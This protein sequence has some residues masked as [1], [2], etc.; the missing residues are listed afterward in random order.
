MYEF[1]DT[2]STDLDSSDD[3]TV[4]FTS[5][6]ITSWQD[7]STPNQRKH[8]NEIEVM[9]SVSNVLVS[10]HKA[11]TS[12]NFESPTAVISDSS[13]VAAPHGESTISLA[14]L[15]TNDRYYRFGFK[16]TGNLAT[17]TVALRAYDVE[18]V[19]MGS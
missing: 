14:G 7:F 9:G 16:I 19:L 18:A 11:T 4:S 15:D 13:L 17:T 3:S 8:L 5:E 2:K 10:I 1:D 12:A 6:A